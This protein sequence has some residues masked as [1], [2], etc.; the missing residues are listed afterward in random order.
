MIRYVITI[1]KFIVCL[2]YGCLLTTW[3]SVCGA[4][5]MLAVN[6]FKS[7]LLFKNLHGS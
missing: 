2:F 7:S 1:W 3:L 6:V 4:L 5:Y